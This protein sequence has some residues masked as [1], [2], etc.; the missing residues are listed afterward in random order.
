MKKKTSL[1]IKIPV[2]FV[3]ISLITGFVAYRAGRFDVYL[4]PRQAE[5]A[6]LLADDRPTDTSKPPRQEIIS[7]SK[8]IYMPPPA[9]TIAVAPNEKKIFFSDT[10]KPNEKPR[11]VIMS[12]SKSMRVIDNEGTRPKTTLIRSLTPEELQLLKAD[13]TVKE[14]E[15]PDS[16]KK[17]LIIMGSSKSAPIIDYK[18]NIP[19]PAYKVPAYKA[20]KIK[21]KPVQKKRS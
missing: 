20:K 7:S 19:I 2:L 18:F 1:W 4:Y 17:S 21:K 14:I 12:S 10:G 8:S 6:G 9:R 5:T 11:E 15:L 3:F 16:V 13:T